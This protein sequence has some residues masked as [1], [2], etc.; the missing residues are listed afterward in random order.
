[1]PRA[2]VSKHNSLQLEKNALLKIE[3]VFLI[4]WLVVGLTIAIFT[5]PG[6]GKDE[7]THIARAEQIAEG[8]LLPQKV[9]VTSVDERILY[10][11]EQYKNLDFYGGETDEA[12]YD[13]MALR[14]P[15]VNEAEVASLNFAFPYWSDARYSVQD[16]L[17]QGKVTW[18]FPN[19]SVN[20]P[21]CYL[22]F[23]L[24]YALAA[25]AG[26]SPVLCVILMRILGVLAYGFILRFAIKKAPICKKCMFFIAL[27]PNCIAVSTVVSADMMTNA[28]TFLYLSFVFR[29]LVNFEKVKT[30]DYVWLGVSL[31][32]LALLK[33]PYVTFGLLLILIFVIN[34]MWHDRNSTLK[35]ALIGGLALMLF[36]IWSACTKGIATYSVWNIENIDS[37]SQLTFMFEHPMT[38]FKAMF[39]QL[40]GTDL[41][42]IEMTAYAVNPIP[43]WI[44]IL[45]FVCFAVQDV[46]ACPAIDRRA[47]ISTC[48]LLVAFLITILIIV[49]LY[50][51]FATVGATSYNGVQSRYF[52]PVILPIVASIVVLLGG[53]GLV[54]HNSLHRSECLTP[55]KRRSNNICYVT[56]PCLAF[57]VVYGLFALHAYSAWLPF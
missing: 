32:G 19:T 41:G 30:S 54:S 48:L 26:A 53:R 42:L 23:S 46:K 12:L 27:L 47:L 33:M 44:T 51:T 52:V 5:P 18:A 15:S 9:D 34:K 39:A 56:S 21:L 36:F 45:A 40:C 17:G 22:P 37:A 3:N 13:L 6:V 31:C 38:A 2:R 11:P 10:V 29:F 25:F 57:L 28:F 20:S 55:A 8:Q 24:G 35:I 14:Y 7:E 4:F 16:H 50:L 49:A 1:M 43:S